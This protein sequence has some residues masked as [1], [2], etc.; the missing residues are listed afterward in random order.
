MR[1]KEK[2][3][4]VTGSGVGI[5]RETALAYAREGARVVVNSQ[6]ARSGAESL[7]LLSA[8]GHQALFVQGDISCAADAQRL[9]DETKR[10]S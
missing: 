8:E 2:V 5:G 10:P 6:S 7:S 3:V 4:L 9:I 1:F